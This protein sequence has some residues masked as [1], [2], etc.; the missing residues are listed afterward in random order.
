MPEHQSEFIRDRMFLKKV[1]HEIEEQD[2]QLLG[3]RTH[4]N[5]L[6]RSG[7]FGRSQDGSLTPNGS[8]IPLV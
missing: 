3:V 1:T 7:K 8:A 6:R 2:E 5:R 4:Q